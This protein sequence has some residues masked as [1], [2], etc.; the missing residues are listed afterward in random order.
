M[1]ISL[2]QHQQ[3]LINVRMKQAFHV[4]QLPQLELAEWMHQEIEQNPL[5]EMDLQKESFKEPLDNFRSS[6][7]RDKVQ[8]EEERRWKEH[9]ESLLI[10]TSSL[11]EHLIQQA[12]F[13][14]DDRQDLQLAEFLIGHLN[15]K[16][17]LETPLEEI[18][19]HLNI[20]KL[21]EILK[22][23]QTL[24]PP[25]VGAFSVQ[26]CLLI[27]LRMKERK[28]PLAEKILKDHFEEL[29]NNRLEAL[30]KKLKMKL[31]DI[32][33]VIEKEILP[34]DIHP[35]YRFSS[36]PNGAIIPDLF[37]FFHDDQWHIEINT[38][39]LPHFQFSKVYTNA[40]ENCSLNKEELFYLR[41]HLS[42]AKWL[43]QILFKRHQT[44]RRIGELILKEHVNFFNGT[45]KSLNPI[46][47]QEAAFS[48]HLHESTVARAISNKYVACPDGLFSLRDFF[49]QGLTTSQGQKISNHS[50]RKILKS[51]VDKED[52]TNPLS[53]EALAAEFK[54][55]GIDC[56][57]RTVAK[58]RGMLRIA[59]SARRKKFKA[60]LALN[61]LKSVGANAD[62]F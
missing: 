37:F 47:M 11:Y 7:V 15:E 28:N 25:G 34:L 4:L 17:F 1:K 54:A 56:A 24:D 6:G 35:G 16:G 43:K 20:E 10:A 62:R 18:A 49:H 13:L 33:Q 12:S 31:S 32:V 19:P 40:M 23:I 30:S 45:Q 9:Q 50:L 51:I 55:R 3:L 41:R 60:K 26:E 36:V 57:R 38:A 21:Q 53:D 59:P 22:Q 14:F 5:L 58:Y 61:R 2:Q 8:E 39:Y 48:L 29:L 27:Q 44:L 46:T 52:K 42:G